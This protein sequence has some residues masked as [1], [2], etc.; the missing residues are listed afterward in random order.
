MNKRQ[1]K[2]KENNMLLLQGRSHREKRK[3]DRA[4]QEYLICYE[5]AHKI[6]KGLDEDEQT[7]IEMGVFTLEEIIAEYG[8]CRTNTRWRQL[9]NLN[10][11]VSR[12]VEDIF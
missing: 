8:H 6:F 10:A 12:H 4:Y 9:R 3:D 5:H 7:L 2:K 1:A 11:R